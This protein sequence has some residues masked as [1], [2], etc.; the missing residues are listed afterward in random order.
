L[1]IQLNISF[2]LDTLDRAKSSEVLTFLMTDQIPKLEETLHIPL[3][4]R[5]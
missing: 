5:Q 3:N 4:S 1:I 2:H